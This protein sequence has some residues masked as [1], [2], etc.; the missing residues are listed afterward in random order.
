MFNR[1]A[2]A[3]GVLLC[4]SA[5]SSIV[6]GHTQTLTFHSNP[7]GA[8]CTVNRNGGVI[9]R[10]TTPSQLLVEKTKYDLHVVCKKDGYEDT[11][12]F[13]KSDVAGATFG[14]IIL[15]GGIGWLVDSATGA[16]NKYQE[17]NVVTLAP[18]KPQTS[19]TLQ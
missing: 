13:I 1:T 19:Q 17:M 7:D 16:D 10:F 5:C 12:H 2:T 6:D 11:T 9:G 4:L 3:I 14:N 15:G 8:E 18:K